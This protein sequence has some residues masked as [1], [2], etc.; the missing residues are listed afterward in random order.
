M[1]AGQHMFTQGVYVVCAEHEGNTGGLTTAWAA[2]MSTGRVVICVGRQSYSRELILSSGAFGVS[3]LRSDQVEVAR[4]FGTKSSR[5]IDKFREVGY[6]TA[7]T[8]SPLLDD[9][10]LWLDC[11]VAS[12]HEDGAVKF[13]IGQ[14][15]ASDRVGESYDPLIYREVDY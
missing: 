9:C 13:I 12:V 1:A 14:V 6:H 4:L 3:V 8:G 15:V 10:A 7:E 5:T 11:R 2:E